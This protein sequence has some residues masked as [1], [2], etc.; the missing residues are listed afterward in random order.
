MRIV[1]SVCITTI[2][3]MGL[4]CMMG[5]QVT[6]PLV[7]RFVE[8]DRMLREEVTLTS[9]AIGVFF[10]I[11]SHE[12]CS[13]VD[14]EDACDMSSATSNRSTDLLSVEHRLK[15]KD[16][17]RRKGAGLIVKSRDPQDK[18]AVRLKLSE[19]GKDLID[20]FKRVLYP[21]ECC[22]A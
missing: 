5:P 4:I 18:R 2:K 7:L 9:E 16:G 14:L 8:A 3:S 21:D 22:E 13:K 15:D 19:K 10:Y 17:T 1:L 6:D 11:A 20:R 12:G